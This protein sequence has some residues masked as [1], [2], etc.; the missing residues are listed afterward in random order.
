MSGSGKA[1]NNDP[2]DASKEQTIK[3]NDNDFDREMDNT[4]A[5]KL[6]LVEMKKLNKYM[7]IITGDKL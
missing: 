6:I 4:C 1:F 2:F 5:L 3:R 7:E